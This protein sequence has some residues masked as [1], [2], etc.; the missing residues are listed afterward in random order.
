MAGLG[1]IGLI[2]VIVVGA[3]VLNPFG[4]SHAGSSGANSG[5]TPALGL[6]APSV[7]TPTD[8]PSNGRTLGKPDAP[9]TLDVWEDYQCPPCGEVAANV[10]PKIIETYVRPGKV[11]IVA[12][13]YIVIDALKGGHESEDAAN[14]ALCAADQSKYWVVQDWIFANQGAEASG[15]FS[16]ARLQEIGRVA[17][18]DMN[19]FEACVQQGTHLDV[20]RAETASAKAGAVHSVPA[21]LV[22]GQ[23]ITP[24]DYDTIAAA[25]DKL[26]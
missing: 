16:P 4:G 26:L 25:I 2:A 24:R 10:M 21:V 23:E 11:K 6:M 19:T 5:S 18:L 7:R 12:H 1:A 20:V 8:I 13:Y 14:V 22:N 15:A 17:G 9:V 3:L